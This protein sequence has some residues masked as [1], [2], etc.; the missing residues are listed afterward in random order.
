VDQK[1]IT[2]YLLDSLNRPRNKV[3]ARFKRHKQWL[4]LNW[5]EY[6]RR[7]EAAGLALAALGIKAGD[8][9]AVLS[10]T[11]LEWAALDFG[12]LGIGA[13]TIPIYQSSRAEEIEFVLQD[14]EPRALIVEDASQLRKWES[15]RARCKS[16]EF[17]VCIEPSAEMSPMVHAWDD[18]LDRGLKV[19]ANN[20]GFFAKCIGKNQIS[21]LAT[22]VYTSG[23]TGNPRGVM[24]THEQILS[25]VEDLVKAF[26]ISEQDSTL[27]FLPY[28]HVLG[29]SEMWLHTY[30][31]FTINFAE[32]IERMKANLAEVSPTIIIGVPRIFEKINAGLMTQIEGHPLRKHLFNWLSGARDPI[33]GLVADKLLFSKL[34]QGLGGKLRFVVSGGAALDKSLA[35]FFKRAGLLILEGYGLTET[36]GAIIVNTPE[37]YEFGTIGKPFGDVE[38]KLGVDGEILI[39]SKKVMK[40]YYKDEAATQ[41]VLKDGYFATGD[42]GEWTEDGFLKI[43]DR[44]KDLIK[45]AGGKYVAPQKLEAMLKSSPL[46]S[47]VLIHGDRRKYVVA[48]VTLNEPYAKRLAKERGWTYRDFKALTQ[49]PEL[50]DTVRKTIAQINTGL[51]SYETIK[52]FAILPEDFTV[53]KGELTP[54][55]K[56]KRKFADKKYSDVIDSL[57][58][59]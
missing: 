52:N 44:K 8:R 16:V 56:V 33:T 4:E 42:I 23:T 18:F 38:V 22:I 2:Q 50:S 55:L 6:Y 43:T 35:Q 34:R 57:Y 26:P 5:Q 14:C 41:E 17:V 13:V 27:S 30:L 47:N 28:A 9:V 21:D 40:G 11:R 54:S 59:N 36:T 19:F 25:E 49:N 12:I 53:E 24:L 7:C 1:P 58:T 10:N 37:S 15:I 3:A 48:L 46:I 32:S 45:T 29:R 51:A 20:K 31:G 39:R